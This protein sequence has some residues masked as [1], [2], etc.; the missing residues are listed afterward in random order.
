M[1]DRDKPIVSFTIQP[2]LK[3]DSIKKQTPVQPTS[4]PYMGHQIMLGQESEGWWA[5]I[6]SLAVETMLYPDQATAFAEAKAFIDGFLRTD[7][8]AP[9][10]RTVAQTLC[11]RSAADWAGQPGWVSRASAPAATHRSDVQ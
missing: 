11:G 9:R 2:D 3:D 1:S 7:R 4:L 8:P 10:P 6:D 5:R